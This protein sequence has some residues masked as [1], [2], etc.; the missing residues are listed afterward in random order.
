MR[1]GKGIFGYEFK[2]SDKKKEKVPKDWFKNYDNAEFEVISRSN[3][4]DFI[5]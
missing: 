1:K 3:Y 2:W 4:L 5:L